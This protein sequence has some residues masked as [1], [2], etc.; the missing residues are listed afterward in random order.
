MPE[1]GVPGLAA[2]PQAPEPAF[3]ECRALFKAQPDEYDS[4]FC[5]YE[6]ARSHRQWHEGARRLELLIV[7]NP[8]NHWPRLT[9]AHIHARLD[10]PSAEGTYRSAA[11]GFK[12]IGHRAGEV[13][14]RVNLYN[15]LSRRGDLELAAAEVE[16]VAEVAAESQ[17]PIVK[18][19]ALVLE[20]ELLRDQGRDL[21]TAYRLLRRA[22]PLVQA[23]GVYRLQRTA[24]QALGSIC[25]RLGRYAEARRYFQSLEELASQNGD[26]YARA[27]FKYN[28]ANT[29]SA[30]M[31]E[32]PARGGRERL[33]DQ[34][35]QALTA[36]QNAGHRSAELQSRRNLGELL[37]R[38]ESD[39]VEALG[40]FEAC[41][42][43]ATEMRSR[44]RLAGCLRAKGSHSARWGR[45][46]EAKQLFDRSL[47]I[48]LEVGDD[49]EITRVMDRI[50]RS[51]GPGG[52]SLPSIE[53]ALDTFESRRNRQLADSGRAELFAAWSDLYSW[54]AGRLLDGRPAPD[55]GAIEKAF[56]LIERLR[57]RVLLE[58]VAG[59][60]PNLGH[61]SDPEMEIALSQVVEIQRT[62]L[63]PELSDRQ[64]RQ[65]LRRLERAEMLEAEARH[66]SLTENVEALRS[67]RFASL[68]EV[69]EALAPDQAILSFQI[70]LWEDI[71]GDFGGGSWLLVST[72]SGTKIYRLPD[73]AALRP[74]VRLFNGLF[75]SRDGSEIQAAARLY[76]QLL[77]EA[78]TE[79]P[80]GVRR[81]IIV[82]DGDLH[83]LPFSA[84]RA[85]PRAPPLNHDYEIWRAPSATLWLHWQE[86]QPEPRA[87]AVLV[88]ADPLPPSVERSS[89]SDASIRFDDRPQAS[90]RDWAL[91]DG[92]RLPALPFSRL[93]ARSVAEHFGAASRL[94]IGADASETFLKATSLAPFGVVHFAAHAV[95][96]PKRP[97][98]SAVL[99][100]A[101]SPVEDGLLQPRDIAGLDFS[102][103]V[104]VLSACQS[105]SG[106]V[107]RGE[108]VM[109]LARSFFAAGA[110]AVIGSLWPMRDDEA[111][112]FFDLFYAHLAQGKT[113]GSALASAQIDLSSR[114]APAAAW[115]GL[116]VLGNGAV[117]LAPAVA[118]PKLT[119]WRWIQISAF[120]LLALCGV[121]WWMKIR[122]RSPY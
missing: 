62:L 20:A 116:T 51:E 22:Q 73:R 102:G 50:M 1:P 100:A 92:A 52:L 37:S 76:Q 81:L 63:N 36:A 38:S 99:L 18:A 24:I 4:S 103:Q 110:T 65:A 74:A 40:H 114:G 61:E 29:L 106:A 39:R 56:D 19:R 28:Q 15:F 68:P 82:P 9:L 41:E 31:F 26:D 48:A 93:E 46:A 33:I 49:P 64:R 58:S 111:A 104:V 80:E 27:L 47:G 119:A 89:A 30:E 57:A 105:A 77:A 67:A 66:P 16:R 86:A 2:E 71:Y 115:A 84:L 75:E 117:S 70:G 5:F 108:G 85:D 79:L 94:R 69:E 112:A 10:P 6:K 44:R 107:L 118:P 12:A 17:N 113:V 13:L 21:E 8:S 122:R 59:S 121:W 43:L 98:R 87:A 23:G 78:L 60:Q 53:Q 120:A 14:A 95:I 3:A 54:P 90:F 25:F 101:G 45:P 96:D 34:Y 11:E 91:A 7:D 72:Q 88:L 42:R 83:A 32:L 97:H 35:R 55:R 109:S